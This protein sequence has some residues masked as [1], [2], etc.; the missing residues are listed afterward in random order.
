MTTYNVTYHDPEDQKNVTVE[1]EADYYKTNSGSGVTFYGGPPRG[2]FRNVQDKIA[3]FNRVVR[4]VTITVEN[5]Q[6]TT[7][8]LEGKSGWD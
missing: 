2:S 7:E 3:H 4:V 1:I 8:D 5:P 6:P